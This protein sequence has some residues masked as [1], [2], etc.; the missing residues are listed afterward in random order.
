MK[1]SKRLEI[2]LKNNEE[3]IKN[4]RMLRY[5]ENVMFLFRLDS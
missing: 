3:L 5:D 4:D 1:I 2:N